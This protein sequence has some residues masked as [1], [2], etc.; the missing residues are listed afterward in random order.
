MTRNT[1]M[2]IML[3]AL[4]AVS[5]VAVS[6]CTPAT[7]R[8]ITIE[9]RGIDAGRLSP[10]I[11]NSKSLTVREGDKPMRA[12]VSIAVASPGRSVTIQTPACLDKAG[13]E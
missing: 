9:E 5:I 1:K 2:K 4:M 3:L 12:C 10:F 6:G 7:D 13:E 11:A 8:F